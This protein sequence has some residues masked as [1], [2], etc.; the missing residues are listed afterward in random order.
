M[1]VNYNGL[2]LIHAFFIAAAFTSSFDIFLVLNLGLNFRISQILLI[3]PIVLAMVKAIQ[4][5]V[6]WPLAF[7]WLVLWTMFILA[8]V[9]NTNFLVR[10]VGYSAWLVFNAFSI[11]ACVQLFSTPSKVFSLVRWYVYS[12]VFVALFGLV[13]FI[14]PALG[15]GDS[16][17]IQQWWLPGILPRLNGFS[18][19]PSY[20]STYLLIGWVIC[21]YLLESKTSLFARSH[22][23]FYFWVITLALILGS[24]R[25]GLLMMLIWYLQYPLRFIGRLGHGYIH[26]R[27]AGITL[28]LFGMTLLLIGLVI[29]FVGFDEISFLFSGLGI[30]GGASHSVDDRKGGMTETLLIFMDS[31]FIGYSLGG[32]APAI[33]QMHGV[34]DI[35]FE[36]AKS[37][38]GLSI[39][40]EVLA[41]S[42]LFGFMPFAMFVLLIISKP[43][44]LARK[45][46]SEPSKVL[47]ALTLS[48]IFELAILQLNQNILRPYLWMHI[49]V[50][51]ACYS[52][53]RR[54]DNAIDTTGTQSP[55]LVA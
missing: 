24:S 9:P 36:V 53:F 43:L 3:V 41:A 7:G 12:F 13:Q 47:V 10:S 55:V 44:H 46:S 6:I 33:A 45:V 2:G 26:K 18:Y 54:R 16:L 17:L 38:E 51:A 21:A 4:N 35:N 40:L 5:R 49:A 19:E 31:P 20:F 28:I 29:N 32:V 14:S 15:L 50:L 25:M 39:F 42:G 30:E 11:F 22:L 48:L 23:R 27:F 8:F 37:Y 34:T 52:A 1:S